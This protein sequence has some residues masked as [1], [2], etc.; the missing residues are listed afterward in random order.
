VPLDP[1]LDQVGHQVMTFQE[2]RAPDGSPLGTSYA[3]FDTGSPTVTW[4]WVNQTIFQWNGA[5]GLPLKVPNGATLKAVGGQITGHVTE[6]G[7]VLSDGFHAFRTVDIGDGV[8]DFRPVY[9]TA[10]SVG[11]V[12]ALVGDEAGSPYMPSLTGTPILAPSA[13]HPNG[14]AAL[15]D[16]QGAVF[17][18]SG[19]GEPGDPDIPTVVELG[20]PDLHYVNPN[21][22]LADGD[23]STAPVYV[24]VSL[25]GT[26]NTTDPGDAISQAPVPVV[27]GVGVA[28]GEVAA[29][30][31]K[32]LFDTGAQVTLISTATAEALGLDLSRPD[33]VGEIWG[34]GD[35]LYE[36]PGFNLDRVELPLADGG[37]LTFTDVPVFVFDAAGGTGAVPTALDGILGMNVLNTADLLLYDPYRTGGPVV[38]LTFFEEPDREDIPLGGFIYGDIYAGYSAPVFS[39]AGNA[40]ADFGPGSISGTAFNDAD[41]DRRRDPLETGRGG[42]SVYLDVNRNKKLDAGDPSTLTAAD[43]R[44]TFDGLEPGTYRVRLALNPDERRTSKAGSYLVTVT[45]GTGAVNRNFGVVDR[46][47][48]VTKVVVNGGAIQ[49]NTVTDLRVIFSEFVAIDPAALRVT[50]RDGTVVPFQLE[51]VQVNGRTEALLTL[52]QPLAN[53]RYRLTI[54]S[55]IVTDSAGQWLD[56]NK[57]GRPGGLFGFGFHRLAG[58][59]NGDGRVGFLDRRLAPR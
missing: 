8:Y 36:V 35:R 56:G 7:R 31:L 4:D 3:T 46:P 54:D 39:L 14:A 11:G 10:A 15:I 23:G 20:L 6:P 24:P 33:Q 18:I 9:G 53:G 44:Y 19:I 57:D 55:A 1:A 29:G 50:S 40:A 12:Q 30:G 32:L 13:R 38:G 22:E 43:G 47:A 52:E 41:R 27:T 25:F 37:T 17:D 2:Y 59:W 26:D 58:D 5:P 45:D 16:M 48:R 21:R 34:S 28:D 42:V 51:V 49:R